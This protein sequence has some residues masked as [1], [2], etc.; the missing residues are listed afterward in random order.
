MESANGDTQSKVEDYE[1]I[2]QI[3]R[4]A[5]GTT[6]L[7][8]HKIEG[9]KYVM[10]KIRLAKQTE[11]FKQMAH[12]EMNLIAKL[13]HPYIVEYKDAWVDKGNYIC[14]IT[15]YCEG[16]DMAE[17]IRK[18]RGALFSEEKLCKWLTQLLLALD[19]LHSSRVIHRDLK[20]SNIFVTKENGIRL[21]DFGLA[22]LLDEGGLTSSVV[23]TP[24][25]MCPELIMDLPY[26]YKSDIW[27]LGCC[28]FEIAAHQQAFRA[29]DMTGLINKINRC[30]ISPLPIIYSPTL[31]QII[32]SMLR[33]SPEHRPTA[34][35]LLR[36]P[37]L[38]PYLLRCQNPS[39][40]F[41]PVKSPV[42]S[43]NSSK[44]KASPG[45][46]SS[47]KDK[48][49]RVTKL[50]EN[51]RILPFDDYADM[52]SSSKILNHSGK[53]IIETKAADPISLSIKISHVSDDSKS[54]DASYETIIS[55]GDY[56]DVSDSSSLKESTNTA[57]SSWLLSN[58]QPEEH[59]E[60]A[61]EHLILFEEGNLNDERIEDL[62]MPMS[63]HVNGEQESKLE[64]SFSDEV[65]RLTRPN[66][67]S[68][69]EPA[70]FHNKDKL[71]TENTNFE[72]DAEPRSC[73]SSSELANE[74]AE[75]PPSMQ[76]VETET[77]A[78]M[79][80]PLMTSQ[81]EGTE[82]INGIAS[83]NLL[84]D[85]LTAVGGGETKNEWGNPTQQRADALESLL[86]LCARLLKQEKLDELAAVLKPFG[87]DA[88]SSRETAIWLTKSLMSARK[89][90]NGS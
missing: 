70:V 29:P 83:D 72:G 7:V 20:L 37:H 56:H 23:G 42:K 19:Y 47:G 1:V 38:Q 53:E 50:K 75:A 67:G 78:D 64:D 32:K 61:P 41:L 26:G 90:S 60:S 55:N 13:H 58:S 76:K 69:D 62:E 65:S 22:K 12:Q 33:K 45:K 40:V 44:E 49:D 31:K 5:F 63:P 15:N 59:D 8:L 88:V 74:K 68:A 54:A 66:E 87:E 81:K 57:G 85:A 39:F 25:Y 35:E 36:H 28:V 43:P 14:I 51:G 17:V 71:S 46:S 27:S 9:K 3:G 73:S 84:L 82:V 30:S 52:Q 18:A 4:G 11:K 16:G 24:I 21:G 86:E 48:T 79:I 89:L 10:K 80:S 77:K 6:F 2:E 34:A